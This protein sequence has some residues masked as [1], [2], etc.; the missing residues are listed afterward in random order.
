MRTF[1]IRLNSGTRSEAIEN[2]VSFVGEDS[3]GSFGIM[4]SHAR[5]MT[6][7]SFGL[8]RFR[9]ADGETE[10]LAVPG[11]LLYFVG[12][13][14]RINTRQYFRSSNYNEM[15]NILDRQLREEEENLKAIKES[16]RRLDESILRRLLTLRLSDE[17]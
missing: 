6:F 16:L 1:L 3:S 9:R 5:M 8:A 14:L 15:E 12:N 10:Y 7:L 11:G 2:V 13:E 17:G 4:A